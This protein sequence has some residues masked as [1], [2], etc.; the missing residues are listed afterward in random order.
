MQSNVCEI[1][2]LREYAR[3]MGSEPSDFINSLAESIG[4]AVW[5]CNKDFD[6]TRKQLDV[7]ADEI[8]LGK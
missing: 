7:R 5:L 3:S 4:Q 2:S 6:H 1:D 8:Q